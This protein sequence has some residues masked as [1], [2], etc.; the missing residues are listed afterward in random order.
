[1]K[2]N[3]LKFKTKTTHVYSYAN[4]C[5]LLRAKCSLGLKRDISNLNSIYFLMKQCVEPYVKQNVATRVG[6]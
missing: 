4:M 3:Y 1:M 5:S 2:S 6:T